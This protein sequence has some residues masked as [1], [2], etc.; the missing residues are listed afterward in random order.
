MLGAILD[1]TAKVLATLPTVNVAELPRLADF[2][3]ILAA[4]DQVQRLDHAPDFTALAQEITEA[5]IEADPFADAVR[6]LICEKHEWAGTAARLLELL[7]P[8]RVREVLAEA[9]PRRLRTPA[10]RRPGTAQ[11]RGRDRVHP[12]PRPVR[13]PPHPARDWRRPEMTVRT[14]RTVRN[15][16]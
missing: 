9:P 5:V 15:P 7:P 2:A 3:K 11:A 12:Q 1:L 10:P 6:A 8:R 4:I 14:V 16:T 13:I